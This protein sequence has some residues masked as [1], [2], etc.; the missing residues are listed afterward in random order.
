[1]LRPSDWRAHNLLGVSCF[2]HGDYERA[3]QCWQHVLELT[4]N[5]AVGARNLGSALY[6]LDRVDE[7]I[8][9]YRHSL[10]IQ[11]NAMAYTNLGTV[12]FF[13]SRYDEAAEVF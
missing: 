7:S 9:V 1:V 4:P 5:N 6:H 13:T 10:D 3:E 11:P 8:H 12:L 2:A